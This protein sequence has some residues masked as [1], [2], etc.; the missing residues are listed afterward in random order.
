VVAVLRNN[1]E[2]G[3]GS[4]KQ[5]GPNCVDSRDLGTYLFIITIIYIFKICFH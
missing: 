3:V 1:G 4:N 2:E 5:S